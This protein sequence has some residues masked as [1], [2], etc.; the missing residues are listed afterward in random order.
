MIVE[1]G[2][3]AHYVSSFYNRGFVRDIAFHA[4]SFLAKMTFTY[5][6][7]DTSQLTYT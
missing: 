6:I 5:E 4:A 2:S 7:T 3:P 1:R